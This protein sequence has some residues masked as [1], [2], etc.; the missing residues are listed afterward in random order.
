MNKVWTWSAWAG[1]AALGAAVA[2]CGSGSSSDAGTLTVAGD[3]PIA[4]A[5][6]VSTLGI[7]PTN[8]GPSAPGGDLMI[9][10]KSSASAVEHNMTA[11]FTQGKGDA[12]TPEVSYDGTKIV[13]SMRCPA[14]M[15]RSYRVVRG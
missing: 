7:N 12:A 14:S 3:V 13:F 2:A 4:Y 10:E 6:R 15:N 11:Q 8:G 5:M 1:A 9:R